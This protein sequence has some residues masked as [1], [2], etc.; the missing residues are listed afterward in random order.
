MKHLLKLVLLLICAA[1]TAGMAQPAWPN[2]PIKIVVGFAAGSPPD[3]FARMY[4]DV[5]SKKM[6]VPVIVDNKPGAAGNLA[7]DY[8]AKAAPDGY[9]FLYTV[10]N[11]FTVNPY[12]YSKL[13]FD[14]KKDLVPVATSM[15]QGLVLV[16]NNNVPA[17]GLK[18]LLAMAAAQ[19]G[20]HSYASYGSGSYS[21]L[22]MEWVLDE[23]KTKML[24]VPYRATPMNELMGGQVDVHIEPIAT[25]YPFISSGRVKALAYTGANRHPALPDVPTFAESVPGVSLTAWHGIWAPAK[26]AAGIVGRF[27]AEMVKASQDPQIQKNI[28]ALNCEPLGASPAQMQAMLD[29]DAAIFSRIVK[30]KNIQL[31]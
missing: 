30:S 29:R 13:P 19:P 22:L 17:K 12:V 14:P 18:E 7:S 2:K 10:A 31:D 4:G 24:H 1:H 3:T 15:S 16:A 5:L 27:N 11:A 9:T 20:K 23:T 6:G 28:R 21:H 26:T 25:A 8:V